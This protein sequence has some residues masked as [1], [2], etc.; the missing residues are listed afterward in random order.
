MLPF[1]VTVDLLGFRMNAFLSRRP[2]EPCPC[3]AIS[4]RVEDGNGSLGK[5]S[6]KT[7][8]RFGLGPR[9]QHPSAWLGAPSGHEERFVGRFAD[10]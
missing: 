6:K 9:E 2:R 5:T 3:N 7:S 4:V 8:Q 1:A 10:E